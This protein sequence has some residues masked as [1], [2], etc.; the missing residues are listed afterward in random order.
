MKKLSIHYWKNNY[1]KETGIPNNAIYDYLEG[2]YSVLFGLIDRVFRAGFNV[3]T[4]F[5]TTGICLMI[6]KGSFHQ[7]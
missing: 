4:Q 3:K 7:S 1:E 5:V 2:D 6:D